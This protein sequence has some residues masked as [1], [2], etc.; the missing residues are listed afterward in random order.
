MADDFKCRDPNCQRMYKYDKCRIRHEQK[1]HN[2]F[3]DE[4]LATEKDKKTSSDSED[5]IF[6]YGCL[7][8]S[9]GLLLR[10]AEDSVKAGDRDRL[11]RVWKFLTFAYRLVGANR[12]ALPGLRIQ[13]SLFG[14]LIPKDSYRFKWNRSS[15]RG[16]Y[17]NCKRLEIGAAQ[18]SW[19]RRSKS[20]V[21][22]CRIS[23]IQ[24]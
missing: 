23:Q 16:W 24:V 20:N 9:L 7:H 1:C 11:M 18:Q 19:Q 2:L 14:P 10:D 17:Q 3:A 4:E 6:N 8:L 22:S 5:H 21:A 13:A 12:Y 15:R